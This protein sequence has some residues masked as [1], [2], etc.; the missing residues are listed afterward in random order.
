M[1]EDFPVTAKN[2]PFSLDRPA[3]IK[4][5]AVMAG[6]SH[7][8][9]SRAIN[10]PELL[11]EETRE[12]IF[13]CIQKLD[14]QPNPF[15]RGLQTSYSKTIALLVPSISNLAF[16]NFTHGVQTALEEKNMQYGLI[17]F[18]S[19][20]NKEKEKFICNSLRQHW[21]DGVIFVSSAGG[22]PPTQLLP[23]KMAKVLVERSN[24][25]QR[26]DS[27]LLDLDKGIYEACSHL[28]H[29]GHRRIAAII[30]DAT[31]ITS[32]ERL[33]AFYKAMSALGLTVK[34]EY[35]EQGMW[36]SR[37]GW[38]AMVK[39]LT[40]KQPPTA[41]FAITD[42]MALGAMGAAGYLGLK[43]PEDVSMI[44]FNNEPGSAELNPPLTTL[45]ASS[46]AMGKHATETLFARI[47][48]PQR[49]VVEI[50]YAV[51]LIHRAS[52]AAPKIP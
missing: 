38:D 34:E 10:H 16:A 12:K 7:S 43:V 44:G 52:T 49:P 18:S 1:L 48:D 41:V 28:F 15:G 40:L 33:Q 5:V 24:N 39:L 26:I 3:T 4:D 21:V 27:L 2:H 42:T 45:N 47:Q 36:T 20:E 13:D 51:T 17:I 37:G 31:S 14:Y 25:S 22:T 9:V 30:G 50:K 46:L 35:V 29:L 32:R 19:D 23:E 6:V 11:S 8:T